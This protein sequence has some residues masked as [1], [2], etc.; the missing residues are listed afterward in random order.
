MWTA[1]A[2]PVENLS[3]Q[4]NVRVDRATSPSPRDVHGGFAISFA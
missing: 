2:N 3:G 4:K 1:G